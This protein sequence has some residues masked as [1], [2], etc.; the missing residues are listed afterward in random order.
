MYGS[1]RRSRRRGDVT[2]LLFE[3]ER[4]PTPH[5]DMTLLRWA[6]SAWLDKPIHSQSYCKLNPE[7]KSTIALAFST[8]GVLFASTHGDHTVKVFQ[9]ATWSILCTLRG[10]RRT[11]W[12]IKFHPRDR[13]ILASGSLDE[14]VRIWD[15][16]TKTCVRTLEFDFVVSCLA[17][18]S[19]GEL[20]AVTSGRRIFLCRWGQRGSQPQAVASTTPMGTSVIPTPPQQLSPAPPA[21]PPSLPGI[22]ERL[23]GWGGGSNSGGGSGGAPAAAAT[24]SGSGGAGNP[25]AGGGSGG[26]GAL[27]WTGHSEPE[28]PNKV[29]IL[30]GE[31]PQRCVAFKVWDAQG[32]TRTRTRT[33]TRTCTRTGD[34]HASPRAANRAPR[35]R[36]RAQ[37]GL[38]CLPAP[39][40][41]LS[42]YPP[43]SLRN[44]LRR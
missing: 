9:C 26:G 18:H 37:S 5:L 11:P 1:S 10:H 29:V 43:P 23:A 14:T 8:D 33:R 3:R 12:T 13:N 2:S 35:F 42:S 20:L 15:L 44:L 36:Q 16:R 6:A 17:F 21:V 34:V 4:G 28:A 24:N 7:A 38:P 32:C 22:L 30:S 27:A 25:S 41:P 31:N 19:S 40:A 39:G